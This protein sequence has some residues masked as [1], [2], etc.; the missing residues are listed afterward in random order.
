M[1]PLLVLLGCAKEI[2]PHLRVD[3]PPLTIRVDAD[4]AEQ[5]EALIRRDPLVRRPDPRTPGVWADMPD[6]DA[7]EAFAAVARKKNPTPSD[8]TQ[9]EMA[10]PGTIAVPLA[11]GARLAAIEVIMTGDLEFETQQLVSGWLGAVRVEARPTTRNPSDPMTWVPGSTEKEKRE[12]ALTMAE[13]SVLLGWLD[14]PNMSVLTPALAL[15]SASHSRLADTP[16]GVLLRAR[17][18]DDRDDSAAAQGR[19]ALTRATLLALA[20]AAA[21]TDKEQVEFRALIEAEG[22]ALGGAEQPVAAWLARARHG[23]TADA[24]N[25]ASTGLALVAIAAERTVGSCPDGACMGL[26]M[27]QSLS[28]ALRWHA[29]TNA[30][31]HAWQVIA[32]KRAA[33]I[34]EVSHSTAGFGRSIP[35]IAE[36][37]SGTGGGS[38]DLS[39]LR[40]RV[41]EPTAVIQIGRLAGGAASADITEAIRAVRTRLLNACNAALMARVTVEQAAIIQRIGRRAALPVTVKS[42]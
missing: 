10:W 36:A 38:I 30:L 21:D 41:K 4:P 11:R 12:A 29:D 8:W 22:A 28:T 17:A 1:I 5:L 40:Y 27:T 32:L 23:L 25:P 6:G 37:L 31:A 18:A 26:D 34:F 15:S 35:V 2:P 16:A 39:L 3:T 20:E 33:D 14:G 9:V 7:I 42:P 19:Y 24:G 13:R